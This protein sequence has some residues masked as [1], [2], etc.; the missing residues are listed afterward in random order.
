LI[1]LLGL[2]H[3]SSDD[4][5]GYT[6]RSIIVAEEGPRIS[7]ILDAYGE[8]FGIKRKMGFDLTPKNSQRTPKW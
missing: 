5:W 4:D 2:K 1:Q 3:V 8:P 7:Q 6:P